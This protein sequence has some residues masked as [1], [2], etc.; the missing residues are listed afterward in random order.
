VNA[1]PFEML[2]NTLPFR[3]IRK[4]SDNLFQIEALLFGTA[5]MLEQ[6]LF[7]EAISDE[8]YIRLIREFK[9]LSSKYSL[10]PLHGWIW[11]FCRL[12]PA[13]FPTVRISQLAAMLSVTGGLFSRVVEA[14]DIR[15]LREI[16]EVTASEYWDDHYI[17]GKISR[18]ISKH[19]GSQAADIFLINAVIPVIF[20]FGRTRN[21]PEIKERALDFLGCIRAEQNTIIDEWG[22]AGINAESAFYSQALLQLRDNYCKKRRCLECRFGAKLVNLGRKFRNQDELVLEP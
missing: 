21:S 1:E 16:F 9:I 11:K 2:A 10:H 22:A 7:R 17:F 6:G 13:N 20:F 14:A 15:Q 19:A 3:I 12:R 18:S 4:H 5:G 8:Y